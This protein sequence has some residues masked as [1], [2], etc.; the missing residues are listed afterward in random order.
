[1]ENQSDFTGELNETPINLPKAALLFA[2]EIAYPALD[3]TYYMTLLNGLADWAKEEVN[4]THD[5][6]SQ[7]EELAQFIFQRL[8][9]QGNATE[10]HD[11]R[12]SYLNE[13]LDRRLGIPITLSVVYVSVAGRLGIPAF[14]IGLPGHFV[15]KIESPG[16]EVFLDPFHGGAL[17]S[18]EDCAR[19]VEATTGYAGPL[20][21]EWLKPAPARAILTRMLNNLRNIYLQGEDWNLAKGVI[22]RLHELEPDMHELLRDLGLIHHK[23]GSLKAAIGYYEQYLKRRPDAPD[24]ETVLHSLQAAA[25]QLAQRN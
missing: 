10:Y 21:E 14:G 11:P 3:I 19:L 22:E 2:K 4:S 24:R 13:V 6:R 7:A 20:Q 17:L 5:P 23:S 1:M 15:V 8:G 18:A 16:E 12:N 25:Q 9:F